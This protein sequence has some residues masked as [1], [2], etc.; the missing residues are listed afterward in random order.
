[1]SFKIL[2]NR[3]ASK[4]FVPFIQAKHTHTEYNIE[5]ALFHTNCKCVWFASIKSWLFPCSCAEPLAPLAKM[6]LIRKLTSLVA[7]CP[8]GFLSTKVGRGK[9]WPLGLQMSLEKKKKWK[10][11]Y[12]KLQYCFAILL[13]RRT[14]G[15]SGLNC[16]VTSFKTEK[17]VEITFGYSVRVSVWIR[18]HRYNYRLKYT[19]LI[20]LMPMDLEG[21]VPF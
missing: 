3:I 14:T 6:P 11:S 4:W 10:S 13:S 15:R 7:I 8:L 21:H 19:L 2:Q 5:K 17:N 1:M 9:A 16:E 18:E 20:P 12:W